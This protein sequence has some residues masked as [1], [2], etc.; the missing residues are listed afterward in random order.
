MTSRPTWVEFESLFHDIQSQVQPLTAMMV[1]RQHALVWATGL[2]APVAQTVY[3]YLAQRYGGRL[4]NALDGPNSKTTTLWSALTPR[5]SSQP[6][7]TDSKP[8]H[9][10]TWASTHSIQ[11]DT[12]D[13]SLPNRTASDEFEYLMA[14]TSG[15]PSGLPVPPPD[16]K[17][18]LK[19]KRQLPQTLPPGDTL[20][21]G[22]NHQP[23]RCVVAVVISAPTLSEPSSD[24]AAGP[25]APQDLGATNERIRD[26][27][28]EYG[29]TL[30]AAIGQD[31]AKS[32]AFLASPSL[33]GFQ[34]VHLN[35]RTLALHTSWPRT[36]DAS[37]HGPAVLQCI[38]GLRERF[39]RYPSLQESAICTFGDGWVA[40]ICTSGAEMYVIV[41][42]PGSNLVTVE[43]CLHR[44]QKHFVDPVV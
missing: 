35:Y 15:T 10:V 29:P 8:P 13:L 38:R 7:E 20:Y 25:M 18:R 23:H 21:V 40:G 34:Y 37:Q 14:L 16:A 28:M 19:I 39:E 36:S 6:T 43:E 12:S 3:W 2:D 5:W 24:G 44:V 9:G 31:Q 32:Q 42:K 17:R 41:D 30:T 26:A 22:V 1:L 4:T 33:K 27:V 11:G